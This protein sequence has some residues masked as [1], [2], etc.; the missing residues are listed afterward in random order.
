MNLWERAI[1]GFCIGYLWAGDYIHARKEHD[2]ETRITE[3]EQSQ[4]AAKESQ[5]A[6]DYKYELCRKQLGHRSEQ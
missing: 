4:L 5:K 1:V 2:L 3:L 6:A